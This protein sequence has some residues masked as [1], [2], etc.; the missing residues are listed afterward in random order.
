[1]SPPR[2]APR[3]SVY[4]DVLEQPHNTTTDQP[5]S[6]ASS[7]RVYVEILLGYSYMLL[8]LGCSFYYMHIVT[9]YLA[10]DMRLREFNQSGGLSFLVDLANSHWVLPTLNATAWDI[11]H[12]AFVKDYSSDA[13]RLT[14]QPAYARRM[15]LEDTR[16]EA[17]IGRMMRASIDSLM[18]LPTQY[19]WVDFKQVWELAH[20]KRRQARCRLR[21]IDNAAVYL[22]A[23]L[24]LADWARATTSGARPSVVTFSIQ[25]SCGQ[26]AH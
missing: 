15:L 12:T 7:F 10:N 25:R 13:T 11:T 5:S 1:M 3:R 16:L 22:E 21:D 19:C 6:D 14:N 9:P 2:V 8:S 24:R 26:Q 23:T 20:T 4:T 17:A 18:N